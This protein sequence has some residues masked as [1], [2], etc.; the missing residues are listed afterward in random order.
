MLKEKMA[1]SIENYI[2]D[3]VKITIMKNYVQQIKN[4]SAKLNL[5]GKSTQI[6]IW[7]RH[8]LDS[9]QIFKLLPENKSNEIILDVGSGAGFPGL[10]LAIMG[11][12]NVVLCEKSKKKAFFLETVLKNNNINAKVYEGRVELFNNKSIKIIVSR[13]FAPL[14]R[15]IRSVFHLIKKDTILIL[16]KGKKYK[17]ELIEALKIYQ[18]SYYYKSSVSSKEGKILVINNIKIR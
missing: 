12:K 13:A 7:E 17:E 2:S 4:F 1:N 18:F 10:V 14:E 16:H 3:E 9:A 15:L 8:I 11:K 6:N 5:I